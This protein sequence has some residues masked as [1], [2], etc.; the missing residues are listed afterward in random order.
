MRNSG[1][2]WVIIAILLILDIYV[3]QALSFVSQC[4]PDQSTR[5]FLI[6]AYW[7]LSVLAILMLIV[8]PYLDTTNWPKSLRTLHFCHYCR[9]FLCQ[10]YRFHLFPG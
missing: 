7:T 4:V 9:L 8:F 2:L 10:T 3:F 1:F 6:S 5:M